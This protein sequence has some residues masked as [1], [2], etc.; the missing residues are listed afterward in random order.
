MRRGLTALAAVAGVAGAGAVAA[1]NVTASTVSKTTGTRT[2]TAT[3]ITRTFSFIGAPN[4]KTVTIVNIDSLTINARCD[5]RGSPIVFGFT[6]AS[7]ADLFGR[8]FDGLGRIHI[9]RNSA[10]TKRSKGIALYP[11]GGDYDTTGTLLFETSTGQVVKVDYALDN[12][13]T[14]NHQ[15]VCTVY[16]SYIAS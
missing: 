12:S 13:T 4:S 14:L 2:I 5:G 8:I 6:S 15:R 16:G 1:E 10:F 11:S 7:A 9:V 3:A